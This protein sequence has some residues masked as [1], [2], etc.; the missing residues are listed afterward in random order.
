MA[1]DPRFTVTLPG[2]LHQ[3]FQVRCALDDVHMG[4]VVIALLEQQCAT[5]VHEMKREKGRAKAK[6]KSGAEAA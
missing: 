6:Q 2:D 3:R 4:D 1:K 5:L